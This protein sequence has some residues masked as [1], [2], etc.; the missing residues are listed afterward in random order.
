M[1]EL[2]ELNFQSLDAKVLLELP[3]ALIELIKSNETILL[4]ANELRV[5]EVNEIF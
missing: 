1:K 2:N 3:E 5:K 4:I